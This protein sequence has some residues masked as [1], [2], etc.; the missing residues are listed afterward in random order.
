MP[1]S[2]CLDVNITRMG[3]GQHPQ[4]TRAPE[5][6]EAVDSSKQETV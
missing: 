4:H 1:T 3:P 5:R 6:E 2:S